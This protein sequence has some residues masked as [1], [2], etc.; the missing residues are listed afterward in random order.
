MIA[1]SGNTSLVI[2]AK[3]VG[4]ANLTNLVELFMDENSFNGSIPPQ[5]FSL[6]HLERLDLSENLIGGTLDNNLGDLSN[7]KE[8]SLDNNLI[9]GKIPL[10]IGNLTNLEALSLSH[11]KL[12]GAILYRLSLNDLLTMASSLNVA[13]FVTLKL[14]QSNYPLWREQLLSLAESQE[15]SDHLVNGFPEDQ[16]FVTPPNPIPENYQPQQSDIFKAWQKSDRLLRGWIYGTLSEESLGLVIGLETVHTVWSALKDAYAQDSQE[17]EFTLRQQLTYFRKDENRSITEH[18][19]LFKELCDSLAAIG[20]KV[21]DEE[22]V[23]CLLTS[24]GP[25]YETFTTTMLKP[26]RPNFNELVSQLK[27]LDQ[28]RVWFS[29]QNES[30]LDQISHVAFYGNQQNSSSNS[31]NRRPRFNSQGRGFQA[32]QTQNPFPNKESYSSQRR[33]PPAGRRRMTPAERELYKNEVCQYCNRDGHIAKICWWIPQ[34]KQSSPAQALSALTLDTD[35]V[36]TDWVADSGASNHMTGNKNLF[37][38]LTDYYGPDSITIGD[39]TFLSIDGVG[40]TS[41]EQKQKLS[42]SNVFSVPALKKNLLSV[43]QLTDDYPVNC[44]FSNVSISVKDRQTGQVLLQGPRKNNLYILSGNPKAYFSNRFRSGTADIWHQRL[45]HPQPSAISIL[46][47]KNLIDVKGSLHSKFLC[48]SCQLGKLSKFPFSLSSN[49]STTVFEKVHCD[50]WGPAPVLSF[51]K[52][53]Y[54]ACLVDDYSKYSWLIPLKKKSDFFVAYKAFEQFVLR[55]FGK[56]IKV[57]HS[58]G[59][60]EFLNNALSSH[61]LSQGPDVLP[62]PIPATHDNRTIGDHETESDPTS[63]S[64]LAA[65]HSHSDAVQDDGMHL[66]QAEQEQLSPPPLFLSNRVEDTVQNSLAAEDVVGKQVAAIESDSVFLSSP[67]NTHVPGTS[68]IDGTVISLPTVHTDQEEL[69]PEVCSSSLAEISAEQVQDEALQPRH[70]MVTRSQSGIVKPNP[71]LA[72]PSL[73]VMHTSTGVLVL[74]IYVD[75]MLLTGSSMALVQNFLQV[76]SKEFSMKDLG[77]LHHFLGIQIQS[78]DSGLQLNQTRYAYSILERAQ[79]VDCQPMP[80][81]LVQRHD[82]VTDPTPVADPTFFRGL[83]GVGFAN[84]TELVELIMVENS[85]NGSILPQL[86]SLR[87]LEKLDLGYNLIAGTLGS[88]LGNLSNLRELRLNDNLF[89]GQIPKQI[90]RLGNDFS[91][92]LP[93]NFTEGYVLG[94]LALSDN[95]LSGPIPSPLANGI[96]YFL[97]L[98]GN[99]FSSFPKFYFHS[100]LYYINLASNKISGELPMIFPEMTG[101]LILSQNELF[102]SLPRELAYLDQLQYLDLHDNNLTGE[103]PKNLGK[104]SELTVLDVSNNKFHG[105]IPNGPQMDRMNDPNSYV[106][107]SGL[108]GMQ[109]R[110]PCGKLPPE[111]TPIE[112]RQE[113]KVSTFLHACEGDAVTKLTNEKIPYFNAPIFLQ[114]K[115]QIGK[116]DEIFG[117]INESYFSIKMMEGIVA[118]SYSPGDKFY[119]DPNKLLPLARFLPQP[120][121]QA[122]AAA[123]GGRGG[124]RGGSRGGGRGGGGFRGRGGPRGGRGGPPR[125]GA[126][127]GGFRGRGRS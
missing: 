74:L 21:P 29:T 108:C 34:E 123:R 30:G 102:G 9:Q 88:N 124:S 112:R 65:H 114:N 8:L 58:D 37:H 14:K 80:T 113:E 17:R 64:P 31:S 67:T 107:N 27:N 48:D 13:N 86:F 85:F 52:F 39:G 59:G 41:I 69:L 45:G 55:Q 77:P 15:L 44:E 81:P 16:K 20:K 2:I 12:S 100:S 5:L 28:R 72:D 109:I 82:A 10:Q 105:R 101:V 19:R 125:G 53:K 18:L 93:D 11:N 96:E 22:K 103:I 126:R 63:E 38:K 121:G 71:N 75:D 35:V 7:L 78:T 62:V 66:E 91:G 97:D 24:L 49:K 56:T 61:F 33:P 60:G 68:M 51:A 50:L 3:G 47:N 118:T 84:L 36:D 40:M 104:L 26:P 110:I 4:F 76:L 43:G 70:S 79:M 94:L 122:Q 95:N 99:K 73:F 106:N 98:S 46:F 111:Q 127:G 1:V 54:Y 90:G 23:F 116:V 120:K 83:V 119:I 32:Q 117:P 115:T 25:Q 92:L 89:H 6:R 42:L 87:H 57:F